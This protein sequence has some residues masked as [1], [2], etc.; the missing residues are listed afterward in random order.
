MQSPADPSRV[1]PK[2]THF[3]LTSSKALTLTPP[4]VTK[5]PVAGS[6]AVSTPLTQLGPL[7]LHGPTCSSGDEHAHIHMS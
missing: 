6:M 5:A 1:T 2:D 4:V 3:A 7:L